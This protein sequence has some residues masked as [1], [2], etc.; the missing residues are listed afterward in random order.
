M[1]NLVLRRTACADE[2]EARSPPA[3]S[4]KPSGGRCPPA[5][6]LTPIGCAEAEQEDLVVIHL[7]EDGGNVGDDGGPGLNRR[8]KKKAAYL[9]GKET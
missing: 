1:R 7:V 9:H 3:A 8:L 5:E 2:G 6:P 4:S